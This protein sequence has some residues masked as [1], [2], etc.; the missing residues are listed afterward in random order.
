MYSSVCTT[1]HPL[2]KLSSFRLR[3]FRAILS[4][5]STDKPSKMAFAFSS[6][7]CISGV[8]GVAGFS[9][10][11][12]AYEELQTKQPVNNANKTTRR[13]R[14]RNPFKQLDTL[15]RQPC[16]PTDML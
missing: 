10:G 15:A 9:V 6:F 1:F 12:P 4:K 7:I 11:G 3:A 16:E 14:M 2:S 8:T 13:D 5:S